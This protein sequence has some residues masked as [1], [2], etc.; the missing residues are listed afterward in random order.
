MCG[1]AV[2]SIRQRLRQYPDLRIE[3]TPDSVTV[4]PVSEDGFTVSIH[5]HDEENYTVSFSGWHEEFDSAAE[6]VSCFFFGLSDQ[7]RLRVLSR[8]SFD[9]RWFVQC[10]RDA[11][12]QDDS[13]TGLLLFPF[14]LRRRERYLQNHVTQV[15]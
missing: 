10:R 9:Y 2:E 15:I 5:E 1:S 14:W 4:F 12:W 8:G 3:E 13:E 6:T 11:V 7:C